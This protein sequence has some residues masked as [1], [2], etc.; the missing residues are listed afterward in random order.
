VSLDRAYDL[1]PPARLAPAGAP[2]RG[3][4]SIC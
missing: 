3:S 4:A 2:A 1:H